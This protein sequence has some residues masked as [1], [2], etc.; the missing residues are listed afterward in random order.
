LIF[1]PGTG[2][3]RCVVTAGTVIALFAPAP[4]L[5][6]DDVMDSLST[7]EVKAALL[8][9][10]AKF[11]EWPSRP[12]GDPIAICVAGD[13]P[14]AAALAGIVRDKSIDG[15][16]LTV[17]QPPDSGTWRGCELLF[18][19]DQQTAKSSAPLR[20]IKTLPVLTVS[21]GKDFSH[22][23]GMIEFYADRGRMR[24]RVNLDAVERSGLKLSSRLLGLATITHN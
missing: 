22:E 4:H 18:I 16:P 3:T 17:E 1:A 9:N 15:H 7:V 13:E 8:Y 12:A 24:F 6:G 20:A 21:D 2:R 19:A 5:A 14:I 23:G 11:A 10:F